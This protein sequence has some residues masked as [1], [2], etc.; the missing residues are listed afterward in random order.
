MT[1]HSRGTKNNSGNGGDKVFTAAALSEKR[2][3]VPR[4]KL[5]VYWRTLFYGLTKFRV[6]FATVCVDIEKDSLEIIKSACVHRLVYR[7]FYSVEDEVMICIF[8]CA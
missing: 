5:R 4:I 1:F 3:F 7:R 8:F 2:V 6:L